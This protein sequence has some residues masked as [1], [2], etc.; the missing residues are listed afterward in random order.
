MALLLIRVALLE[1]PGSEVADP[2]SI[3][4]LSVHVIMDTATLTETTAR[5]Y[6]PVL[7]PADIANVAAEASCACRG[8]ATH[9]H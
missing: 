2:G 3:H 5:G 7:D 4:A 9:S 8:P 6:V 1:S